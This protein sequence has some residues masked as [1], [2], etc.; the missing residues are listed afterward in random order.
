MI[1][2]ETYVQQIFW[3]ANSNLIGN[4]TKSTRAILLKVDEEKKVFHVKGF[5]NNPVSGLNEDTIV[6]LAEE[7][8]EDG[9]RSGVT[10]AEFTY[11]CVYTEEKL[12]HPKAGSNEYWL[13]LRYEDLPDIF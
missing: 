13:F 5:F 8:F 4:V 9:K 12:E 2:L 3:L 1:T 6:D 11:E 10:I 7:M